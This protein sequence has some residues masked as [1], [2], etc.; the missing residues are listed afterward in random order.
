MSRLVEDLK[1]RKPYAMS[2]LAHFIYLGLA[3]VGLITFVLA[4]RLDHSRAWHGFLVNYFFWF[5]LSLS[6]LFFTALNYVTGAMWASPLKR[7]PESLMGFLPVAFLLML[8]LLGGMHSLYEWTHA[9]AVQ[10][11]PILAAKSGYLNL[12]FFVIRNVLFFVVWIGVGLWLLKNSLQQDRTGDVGLTRL[13][14]TISAPFLLFFALSFTVASFDW[15]MSLEPHW[16]STIFGVYCFAG[17]FESGMAITILFVLAL[18]KQG[19]LKDV[20]N[21]NHL[22]DLGKLMFAF[23]VFW[24][25]IAF[26]QYMLI[27]YGNLP[28]ET[29]YMMKRTEGPWMPVAL[30]LLIGKFI[31][32]FFLLINR[33]AKR[34]PAYL[35]FVAVWV[36]V[37]QWVDIYWIVYPMVGEKPVFGWQ[38]I[39]MTLGFLGL[40]VL[41]VTAILQRVRPIAIHDPK[42][43]DGLHHHQ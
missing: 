37:A 13:N 23:C 12:P 7:I 24:T 3:L 33:L 41:S 10:N 27:W 8:V 30:F 31:I 18:R 36:L 34:S 40:F 9:E 19:A 1:N 16:F 29:V 43:S 22:H 42:L 39:G 17:L 25:Y 4:F 14:K 2:P 6:G 11:D 21:E 32:P 26:S 35:S 5:S 38:E 28:E 15:L 20:V